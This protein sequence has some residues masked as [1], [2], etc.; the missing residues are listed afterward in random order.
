[1]GAACGTHGS[2]SIPLYRPL[3]DETCPNPLAQTQSEQAGGL[4]CQVRY[5]PIAAFW[6]TGHVLVAVTETRAVENIQTDFPM[7]SY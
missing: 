1:M 6:L 7:F 2:Q 3:A 5:P 4:A